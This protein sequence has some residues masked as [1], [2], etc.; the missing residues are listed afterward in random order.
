[1]KEGTLAVVDVVLALGNGCS[2]LSSI[3][4][5]A[6]VPGSRFASASLALTCLFPVFAFG[7]AY[8]F[9][10]AFG[11]AGPPPSRLQRPA[12][13]FMDEDGQMSCRAAPSYQCSAVHKLIRRGFSR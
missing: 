6:R 12:G 13:L 8:R 10:F 11:D 5:N 2:P 4:M 9:S 7:Q 3:A 1:M